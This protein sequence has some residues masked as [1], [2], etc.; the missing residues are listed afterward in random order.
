MHTNSLPT[1]RATVVGVVDPDAYAVGT[2]DTAWVPLKDFFRFMAVVLVGTLGSAATVD[3][4][5]RVA[6]NAAGAN[7]ADVAGSSITQLT[8]AGADSDKQAIINFDP[9]QF[10][11]GAAADYTHVQLRLTVG[12]AASDAGAVLLGFDPR[13]LPAS[14]YDASTVDEI[15]SVR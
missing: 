8:Q 7:A 13:F 3:A 2:Y 1:E 14:D 6:T 9:Q 15:K 4:K 11:A 12:T 5:L 10:L